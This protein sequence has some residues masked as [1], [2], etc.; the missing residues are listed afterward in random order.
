MSAD[1]DTL[2]ILGALAP[3]NNV[4]DKQHRLRSGELGNIRKHGLRFLVRAG[5]LPG[6]D[7]RPVKDRLDLEGRVGGEVED[8]PVD[9]AF[10]GPCPGTCQHRES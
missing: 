2:T 8:L 7:R 10:R 6:I 9:E 4:P 5:S 3:R 1:V